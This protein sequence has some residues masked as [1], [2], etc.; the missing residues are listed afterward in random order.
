VWEQSS[1]WPQEQVG[2]T[3]T[4]GVTAAPGRTMVVVLDIT[5]LLGALRV[6]CR[7]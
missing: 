3:A 7:R 5:H 2:S 6:A 1:A 4:S